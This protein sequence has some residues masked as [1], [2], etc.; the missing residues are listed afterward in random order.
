MNVSTGVNDYFGTKIKYL[1][2]QSLGPKLRR[3]HYALIVVEPLDIV[4]FQLD[5]ITLEFVLVLEITQLFL[6]PV[7]AIKNPEKTQEI[8]LELSIWKQK[9]PSWKVVE[10]EQEG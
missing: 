8:Q 1:V 4:G 3:S 5:V 7:L 9:Q 6:V 2:E 10:E